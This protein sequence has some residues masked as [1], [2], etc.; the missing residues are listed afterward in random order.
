LSGVTCDLPLRAV[1]AH[2]KIIFRARKW[3][4]TPLIS[5]RGRQRQADL[6]EF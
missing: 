5:A 6:Y 2:I 4:H 1:K 3:W